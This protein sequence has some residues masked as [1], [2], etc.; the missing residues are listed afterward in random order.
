MRENLVMAY[1]PP[2][3]PTEVIGRRIS[4]FVIDTLLVTGVSVAI[5][6]ALKS[7][8]YTHAPSDA[9]QQLRDTGVS[10][11]CIQ[12]GS[13]AYTWTGGRLALA[14]A[15]SLLAGIV[16]NV[17]LQGTTGASVGKMMLGLRVVDAG[18]QVCGF[19]RA[20]VRWLFLFVDQACFFIVGLIV[21]LVTHPHRRVGDMIAGTYVV[22]AA[23][24]GRP[25][26]P[27]VAMPPYAYSG[28]GGWSPPA[29]GAPAWGA[30]PPPPQPTWGAQPRVWGTEPP[31]PA[32][33]QP[34]SAPDQ[35]PP[36]PDQPGW[37]APAPQ[38]WGT[39]PPPAPPAASPPSPGGPEHAS[40]EPERQGESWWDKALGDEAKPDEQ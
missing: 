12:L 28:Q 1:L 13:R 23:D 21:V 34:P 40:E 10:D 8:A 22:S 18:G 26:V 3:D 15:L 35:Q 27:Q 14:I 37:A 30:P 11:T 38:S 17:L 6:A 39:P 4:A 20:I 2:R 33:Y 9:C 31:P 16:N 7:N 25:V 24:A 29:P 32:P 19:G 36:A 5:F